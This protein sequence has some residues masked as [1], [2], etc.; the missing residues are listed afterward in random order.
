MKRINSKQ[1]NQGM[2]LPPDLENAYQR[3][4]VAGMKIMFSPE[5]RDEVLK[6]IDGPGPMP[7]K[8][9]KGIAGL[10]I[11]LFDQSNKT[12]PPQVIIPAGIELLVHAG[13]FLDKSGSE[14]SDQEIGTAISLM[15]QM[16]LKTFGI[17]PA[18]MMAKLGQFDSAAGPVTGN[19]G[20][21]PGAAPM[22]AAPQGA[23]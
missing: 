3:V 20:Q 15:I 6:Q 14:V 10:M 16:L 21:A 13:E 18:K 7:E 8:L 23:A 4:V 9:A 22:A 19:A 5:T 2:H 1:V 11:L 12:M 17:D